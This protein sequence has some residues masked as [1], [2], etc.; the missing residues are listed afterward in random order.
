M[1]TYNEFAAAAN[2]LAEAL[3]DRTTDLPAVD[4]T[5]LLAAVNGACSRVAFLGPEEMK[6]AADELR[7]EARLAVA[8]LEIWID[9]AN[10][11][12][13][14]DADEVWSQ[15]LE[16]N[17]AAMNAVRGRYESFLAVGQRVLVTPPV[18]GAAT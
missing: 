11:Q 5:T 6:A 14:D 17:G 12:D 2:L 4:L 3:F 1:D 9:A 8:A 18:D 16:D 10:E 15:C 7:I 13:G